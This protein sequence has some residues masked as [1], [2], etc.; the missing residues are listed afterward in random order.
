MKQNPIF[1]LYTRSFWFTALGILA[2]LLGDM[3]AVQAFAEIAALFFDVSVE[4][5]VG[6]AQKLA[7]GVAF[8]LA[9]MERRGAARPYSLNPKDK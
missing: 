6:W 8:I 9:V 7:P 4:Q 3:G 1:I 2:L 5:I